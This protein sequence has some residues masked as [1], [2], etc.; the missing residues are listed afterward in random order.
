MV[1]ANRSIR[2]DDA[3]A[4]EK[5]PSRLIPQETGSKI[6]RL[7]MESHDSHRSIP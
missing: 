1:V 6:L 5:Q 3:F 4:S 2:V 7:A